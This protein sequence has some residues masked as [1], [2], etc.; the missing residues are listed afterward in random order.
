MP[1]T[2]ARGPRCAGF[3]AYGEFINTSKTHVQCRGDG[4]L[5]SHRDHCDAAPTWAQRP[6]TAYQVHQRHVAQIP[7]HW[8]CLRMCCC[9]HRILWAC[10]GTPQG[11]CSCTNSGPPKP[12]AGASTSSFQVIKPWGVG[13]LIQR[14]CSAADLPALRVLLQQHLCANL[15][16]A[17]AAGM[18]QERP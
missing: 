5:Q 7:A 4:R 1:P 16:D 17:H 8:N 9:R 3:V 12:A 10:Q 18:G 11:T 14:R 6:F 15:T 13:A 2:G